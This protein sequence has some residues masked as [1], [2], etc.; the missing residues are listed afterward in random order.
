LKNIRNDVDMDASPIPTPAKISNKKSKILSLKEQAPRS[1][2]NDVLGLF[3]RP[4]S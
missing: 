1:K 2:S 4:N 3:N